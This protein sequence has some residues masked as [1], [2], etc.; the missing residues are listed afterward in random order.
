M[1][2]HRVLVVEDERTAREALQLIFA[3]HGWIV[4]EA[5]TVAEGLAQLDPPPDCIILDLDLPDG[6]GEVVL[7]RVRKDHLL[8]RVTITTGCD[9]AARLDAVAKLKPEGLIRKPVNIEALL[10]ACGTGLAAIHAHVAS[11]AI[12]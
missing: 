5:A 7:Q 10:A 11:N 9:D 2:G 12:S 3:L 8:S 4:S 1:D 6:P